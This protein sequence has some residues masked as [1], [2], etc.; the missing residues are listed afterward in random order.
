MK[1]NILIYAL[2]ALFALNFTS[3]KEEKTPLE[4]RTEFLTGATKGWALTTATSSPAY[5]MSS[6]EYVS[7]LIGAGYLKDFEKD[8]LVIYRT[9]GAVDVNPGSVTDPE[10]YTTEKNIGQWKFLNDQAT[11]LSTQIPFFMDDVVEDV[12]ILELTKNTLKFNYT[13]NAIDNPTK[14]VYT[15]TLTYTRK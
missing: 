15:F 6:G 13:H 1:R 3:C 7:D 2:C 8:D 14:E 11:E 10:G 4:E 9:T 5:L 12:K